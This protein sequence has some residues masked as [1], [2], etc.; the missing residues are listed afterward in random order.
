[1]IPGRPMRFAKTAGAIVVAF[2]A[3]SCTTVNWSTANYIKTLT[4][5]DYDPATARVAVDPGVEPFNMRIEIEITIDRDLATPEKD[6]AEKFQMLETKDPGERAQLPPDPAPST[7]IYALSGADVERMRKTAAAVNAEI[8]SK[9]NRPRNERQ[10]STGSFSIATPLDEATLRA[11]CPLNPRHRFSIWFRA[12]QA[13]GY[14]ALVSDKRLA[15]FAE[16]QFKA[17]CRAWSE[18]EAKRAKEKP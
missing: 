6:V 9:Q 4:L 7:R 14:R 18:L 3:A 10:R 16:Q 15:G 13:E 12:S 8:K 5:D 2:A 17:A 1:M 11:L